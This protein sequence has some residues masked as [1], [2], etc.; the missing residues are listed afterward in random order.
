[1]S[2]QAARSLVAGT[3]QGALATLSA[4]GTPWSSLV[5]FAATDAGDPVL[6]VSDLA[7]H[8]RNLHAEPRASLLVAGSPAGPDPLAAPR[9]TLAGR[10]EP[11]DAMARAVYLDGV[12]GAQA[13]VD[14]GDF[15]LWVLRVERVRWVGGY[16]R[17]ATIDAVDYARA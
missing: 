10:V 8:G 4:D 13:Y 17:M 6:C 15:R 14:M 1:M 9:V 3:A 5:A 12:P 2:A 16:A 11:G 7:E